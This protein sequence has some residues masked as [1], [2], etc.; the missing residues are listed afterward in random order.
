MDQPCCHPM[1]RGQRLPP[2][3]ASEPHAA[4]RA[5]CPEVLRSLSASTP[6]SPGPAQP[7]TERWETRDTGPCVRWECGMATPGFL[8]WQK[9]TSRA[10]AS[11]VPRVSHE[12]E[13]GQAAATQVK[14]TAKL[15]GRIRRPH[16]GEE[17][18]GPPGPHPTAALPGGASLR[19]SY[20]SSTC[21]GCR[22][23]SAHGVGGANQGRRGPD[24]GTLSLGEAG[25]IS[26]FFSC[27]AFSPQ[28]G[29]LDSYLQAPMLL[30][31]FL[32]NKDSDI[33][34]RNSGEEKIFHLITG[35]IALLSF[36]LQV[37]KPH[38]EWFKQGKKFI[39]S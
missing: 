12:R 28:P 32:P 20:L 27:K 13:R 3:A 18:P 21:G 24:Q 36:C 16:R 25:E 19:P 34:K 30:E 6:Q 4:T 9:W 33:P 7:R 5:T 11:P 26:L 15:R 39:G 35:V 23:A 17:P 2:E 38:T 1:G 29:P 10:S 8:W 31:I 37:I 22:L 14:P